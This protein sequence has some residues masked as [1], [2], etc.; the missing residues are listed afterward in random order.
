MGKSSSFEVAETS[1]EFLIICY[2]SLS[3]LTSLYCPPYYWSG[4]VKL[5]IYT[6]AILIFFFFYVSTYRVHARLLQPI[7][8]DP[9]RPEFHRAIIRWELNDGFGNPGYVV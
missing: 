8:T 7:K 3:F 2:L 4:S 9:T 5:F 1:E 6:T